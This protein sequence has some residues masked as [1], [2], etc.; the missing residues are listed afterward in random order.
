MDLAE[1]GA[2][3]SVERVVEGSVRRGGDR[4][5]ITGLAEALGLLGSYGILPPQTAMPRAEAA[6]RRALELDEGKQLARQWTACYSLITLQG[7]V[8]E[9]LDLLRDSLEREPHSLAVHG[10]YATALVIAHEYEQV[11]EFVDRVLHLHSSAYLLWHQRAYA[12][13]AL[14]DLEGA[15][16]GYEHALSLSTVNAWM[17]QGLGMTLARMGD[18]AGA[19]AQQAALLAQ[20]EAGY[21]SPLMLAGIPGNL[22]RLDEAYGYLEEG[23]A[24]RDALMRAV[25]SWEPL[26]KLDGDPRYPSVIQRLNLRPFEH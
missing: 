8:E 2:H 17:R 25:Q 11:I 22:G 4:V 26:M 6:A 10:A 18:V 12:H 15:R 24:T 21:V 23:I 16:A 19:E 14:G 3:L 1:V 13:L 5:R 7:R 20:G 9:G